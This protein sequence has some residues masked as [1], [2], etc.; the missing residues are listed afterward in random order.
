MKNCSNCETRLNCFYRG[1]VN[2]C[3][4]WKP[5]SDIKRLQAKAKQCLGKPLDFAEGRF[6]ETC[7]T[8][9]CFSPAQQNWLNNIANR[10]LK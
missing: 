1:I 2:P 10:V 4:E 7:A 6:V 8:A 9:V 5:D 3:Q